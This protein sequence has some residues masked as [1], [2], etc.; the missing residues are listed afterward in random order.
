MFLPM[1][2]RH[3]RHFAAVVECGNLSKAADRIY[4]SQPALTR[5]I[6]NLEDI[7]GA[8]LLERQPRGV[9]PTPAG[10]TLYEYARLILNEAARARAEVK[11]VEA[12]QRGEVAIGIAAMF[13]DH[14]VDRAVAALGRGKEPVAVRV[15]QGFYED[16]IEDLRDGTLD[17]LFT[18]LPNVAMPD[19]VS[20]EPVYDVRA[21]IWVNSASALGR[22]G[23]VDDADLIAA[24][25]AIV[26]SPHTQDFL[27]RLLARDREIPA[28]NYA[29]R[30][31]SLNLIRALV[32]AED[33]VTLLPD[34]LMETLAAQG[35]VR[36]LETARGPVMRRA[37]I[38]RRKSAPKR[39]LL[40]QFCAALHAAKVG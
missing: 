4:I 38:I 26:E 20:V 10:A 37:V 34:H 19:D 16:L 40:E 23:A 36:R 7:V 21:S 12:G 11:A 2:L 35:K 30:T 15:T 8:A 24:R 6:K 5:S 32:A 22:S 14:I 39:P 1:E 3:L 17:L 9:V 27:D 28:M 33:Y 13:A 25:W 31:N 29:V 18:N